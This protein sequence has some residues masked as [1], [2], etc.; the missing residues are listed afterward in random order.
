M[1][2][3]FKAAET[4]PL[5]PAVDKLEV[6]QSR[7]HTAHWFVCKLEDVHQIASSQ[8]FSCVTFEHK[9]YLRLKEPEIERSTAP[10]I[11]ASMCLSLLFSNLDR[12]INWIN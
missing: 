1:E 4:K 2:H 11:S 5:L 10:K 7:H 9:K 6:S 12:K 3:V 8:F